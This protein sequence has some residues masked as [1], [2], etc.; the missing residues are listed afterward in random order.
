MSH[1]GSHFFLYISVD[2]QCF[3]PAVS[4][5]QCKVAQALGKPE[6][7]VRVQ[8]PQPPSPSPPVLSGLRDL[9]GISS[10]LP[11]LQFSPFAPLFTVNPMC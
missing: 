1:S 7:A 4:G 9:M 3:C 10:A 2:L 6:A 5:Q 8:V 11:K